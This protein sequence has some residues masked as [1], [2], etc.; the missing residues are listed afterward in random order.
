VAKQA[1]EVTQGGAA[2]P[3][4]VPGHIESS[5]AQVKSSTTI[6]VTTDQANAMRGYISGAE[7][8][9]Q[10]YD[11]T[12]HNCTNFSEG[13]LGAGGIHAPADMTP[14]GLVKDLSH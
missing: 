3:E 10:S 12:Y 6:Y 5:T 8:S 13:V 1:V 4:S 11:A 2:L 7:H 9:S 14:G